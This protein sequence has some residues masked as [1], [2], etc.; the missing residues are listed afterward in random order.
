M[1]NFRAEFPVLQ[2]RLDFPTNLR[3][4]RVSWSRFRQKA[5]D[6]LGFDRFDQGYKGGGLPGSRRR[7]SHDSLRLVLL[8]LFQLV[9]CKAHV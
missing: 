3:E 2:S 1:S 7:L 4:G 6:V 9:S 5:S 8:N